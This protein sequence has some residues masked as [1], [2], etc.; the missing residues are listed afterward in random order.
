MKAIMMLLQVNH[1][2]IFRSNCEYIY[3][4]VVRNMTTQNVLAVC[5]DIQGLVFLAKT[6]ELL[7][8]VGKIQSS[9]NNTLRKHE[10]KR[11]VSRQLFVKKQKY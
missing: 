1:R 3:L 2:N 5:L 11:L 10:D 4:Y 8:A 7:L 9:I 6:W